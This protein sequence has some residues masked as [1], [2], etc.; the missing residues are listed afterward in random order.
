M[1]ELI[2]AEKLVL[3]FDGHTAA[4]NV[5]FTLKEGDYLCV[6]GENGS[7]K[8]TL[9][10]AITGEVRPAGGKLELAQELLKKGIGYLP[11]KSKIQRDFPASV[12]EVVLSGCTRRDG[13]G[14]FWK[15]ESKKKAD[16][17]MEL[18][19]IADLADKC[20]GDLSGGQQQRVLLARA[21]CVSD[22]L[23]LLD[24][25]VTGLDPDAAHEMYH[26]IR[27]INRQTG[28]AVM[29]VSHD[30]SCALREADHV[31]SMCRGHSFFGTVAEYRRHEQMDEAADEK[32]HAG[33]DHSH[34]H[35][36]EE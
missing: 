12:R 31:L 35:H 15:K 34:G 24:E 36:T 23:L 33:H 11:Q 3:A 17:A 19:R 6:V 21:V 16:D 2:K 25:P 4:E 7:G 5:H 14:L 8:S 13:F 27:T 20:Y 22:A 32:R 30:V 1:S 26:T 29:M 28:C 18:L 9:L 10:R